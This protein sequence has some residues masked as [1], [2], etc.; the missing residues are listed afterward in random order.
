MVSF[1]KFA[2]GRSAATKIKGRSVPK[3]AKDPLKVQVEP[4]REVTDP[5]GFRT[6]P[7][8]AAQQCSTSRLSFTILGLLQPNTYK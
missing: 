7:L 3:A 6:R 5:Y 1:H 4:A 2:S 8:L